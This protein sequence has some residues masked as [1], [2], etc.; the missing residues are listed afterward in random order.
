MKFK[1]EKDTL[2]Q[3]IILGMNAFLLGM[4]ILYFTSGEFEKEDFWPVLLLL[5][6]VGFLFWLYFGTSYELT[7][8]EGL[9][10]RSGPFRGKISID[11]IIEIRKGETLWAGLKP[12]T[13]GNGL[14]IRYDKYEEIYISPRTNETFIK[15]ALE[16]NEDIKITKTK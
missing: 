6:T 13:S 15:R 9:I 3:I 5:A 12:A 10:Y 4:S 14:I 2:F 11:R 16:L 8:E 7:K 1:S